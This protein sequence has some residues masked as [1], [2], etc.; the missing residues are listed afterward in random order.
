VVNV[1]AFSLSCAKR[2]VAT[3]KMLSGEV[4]NHYN[5]KKLNIP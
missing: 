4:S 1:Y 2:V 5:G 3:D